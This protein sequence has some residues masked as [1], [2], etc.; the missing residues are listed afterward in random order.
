MKKSALKLIVAGTL[1][2]AGG[3]YLLFSSMGSSMVYY[4]T[5]DEVLSNEADFSERGVRIS[6]WV[7]PETVRLADDGK[8]IEFKTINRETGSSMQVD[9]QGIV[10]DTFKENSEVVVE[11]I[12]DSEAERFH[13]SV[14][15]A[16]CPSKYEGR[17]ES[18][19]EGLSVNKAGPVQ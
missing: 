8:G 5:V 12:W 7:K 1:I 2:M 4:Y 18:H 9:Y 16:K 3:G 10:P 15:L 11:G 13:A 17:G 14:L 6:G 19:P